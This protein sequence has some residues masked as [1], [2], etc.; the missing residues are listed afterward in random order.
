M[1]TCARRRLTGSNVINGTCFLL[2]Q[3]NRFHADRKKRHVFFARAGEN[4]QVKMVEVQLEICFLRTKNLY[5]VGFGGYT[6]EERHGLKQ[7]LLC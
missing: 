6:L 2:V 1:W 4:I 3:V 7:L 5:C